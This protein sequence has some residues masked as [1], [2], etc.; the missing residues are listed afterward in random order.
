MLSYNY[1]DKVE[2]WKLENINE[3]IKLKDIEDIRFDFKS[4]DLNEGKGLASHICAMANTV[5]GFLVLGIEENKNNN[6]NIIEFQKNGFMAG[7]EDEVKRSISNYISQVEP[8]PKINTLK[9]DENSN[10]F[11]FVIK[12]YLMKIINHTL[13]K[14]EICV[15]LE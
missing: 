5:G 2:E 3:L 15:I 11:Y 6:G 8:L 9:I 7:K 4:K 12:I 10:T 1:P 13:L 14:I